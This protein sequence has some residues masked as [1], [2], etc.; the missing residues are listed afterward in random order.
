M[1]PKECKRLAEVDFPIKVVSTFSGSDK[2]QRFKP[3]TTLHPWWAQRPLSACRSILAALLLPDPCDQACPETFKNIARKI[4]PRI[5]GKIGKNDRDLRQAMLDFVGT[6][7]NTNSAVFATH[8]QVF[9]ELIS[10]SYKKKVLV[11]DPFAGAGSIPFEAL[12]LGCDSFASDLNP[13]SVLILK[14]ILEEVPRD[15]DIGNALQKAGAKLKAIAEP[16]LADL[17]PKDLDGRQPVAFLWARSVRCESPNCGAE[18]PL[19]RSFWL[20][21]KIKKCRALRF[22]VSKSIAGSPALIALEVFIPQKDSDVPKANITRAKAKCLSCDTV[23]SPDR[24]RAQLRSQKG[25]CEAIFDKTGDRVG[26]ARIIAVI[27]VQPG[28]IIREYRNAVPSDYKAVK[29]AIDLSNSLAKECAS[30]GLSW[31]PEE[32]IERVPVPFGVINV[33]L[34]GVLCWADLY[35]SRQ[36]ATIAILLK[37]LRDIKGLTPT[38]RKLLAF[39]INKFAR[40]CNANAR[41]N[42]V[43]ESVEPAFGTPSLPF[44]WT[45]PESIVWGPWAEN[46]DGS[47]NS[48]LES[49]KKGF[50]GV[51]KSASVEMADAK[52]SPLPDESADVWFTDP[53]YYDNIPYSYISDFFY[54]WLRRTLGDEF[55]SV[56]QTT[57]TPKKEELVAYL[58]SDGNAKAARERFEKGLTTAAREGRRILKDSGI[59]C[60]VFAHKTTEGWEALL[61]GIIGSGWKITASWPVSTERAGRIRARDS[62]ALGAS[63]HLICRPRPEDADVGDWAGV[64]HE[65]P[66]RVGDWM[67]RLQ[68]EGVRGADLVF[69]CIGPALEI[70]SRYRK[71]ETAE[72]KEVALAEFLEKVW[73]VV[74][75]SALEQVLGTTEAHARNGMADVL[76]EDARLTALF[77]WTLQASNGKDISSGKPD[78]ES[79]EELGDEEDEEAA[80]KGNTLGFSLIFDVVRRFAQPLGIELPKWENRII[81]T[82]KGTVRLMAVSERA[83]QLFGEDGAKVATDWIYQDPTMPVQLRLFPELERAHTPK[84]LSQKRGKINFDMSAESASKVGATTLDR[85]HAS[86]LLQAGGQAN[87][88]RMLIKAEQ[89]RGSDFLRLANALSALYPKGSEEKRLLDAMLLAVPR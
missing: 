59:G 86:M 12:R 20:C 80:P 17:Y 14:T 65:L 29:R 21:K 13:V 61:T 30:L 51:T 48:I 81:E 44:T 22:S 87:A 33:W 60:V 54:V 42:N 9:L 71:V 46:Y 18:I 49:L 4:L 58:A 11:A 84:I 26:G 37:T 2:Y 56:F 68:G 69:S 62:A 55:P 74:G 35:T 77:L 52:E 76:E 23:L 25:G 15:T 47:L 43:V 16:Q 83:K 66:K 75:R 67:E 32:P 50:N 5:V 78:E 36:R 89:D 31:I 6:L 79:V 88:L 28:S 64:L 72:G 40:H 8:I 34:Y 82:K 63:I 45:F 27:T 70:F 85:V 53:P 41:W 3:T 7:A 73:E 38:L 57:L 24:V 39:T 10:A 19:I 1:I